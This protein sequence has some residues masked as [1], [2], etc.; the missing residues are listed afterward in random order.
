MKTE[1]VLVSGAEG[2]I[3][4]AEIGAVPKPIKDFLVDYSTRMTS[5]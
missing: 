5:K 4:L 1:P 3:L 2:Q